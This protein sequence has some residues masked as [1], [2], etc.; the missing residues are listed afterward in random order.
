MHVCYDNHII[1]KWLNQ[2]VNLK[3]CT[4][5]RCVFM[6]SNNEYVI[7]KKVA[8][9]EAV[10]VSACMFSSMCLCKIKNIMPLIMF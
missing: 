6:T 9:R 3:R 1:I 4:G 2:K 5:K 10:C 8:N 7:K